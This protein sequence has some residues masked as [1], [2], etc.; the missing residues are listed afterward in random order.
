VT[1]PQQRATNEVSKRRGAVP[2]TTQESRR[3]Y[4][5]YFIDLNA[6]AIIVR[7]PGS[8]PE[9]GQVVVDGETAAACELTHGQ[10][11]T[12]DQLQALRNGSIGGYIS[13]PAAPTPTS[14]DV[15]RPLGKLDPPI[16]LQRVSGA[17][18]ATM[19]ASAVGESSGGSWVPV[20]SGIA[21]IAWVIAVWSS[22]TVKVSADRVIRDNFD[23]SAI[24]I[25]QMNG[26]VTSHALLA[27]VLAMAATI[28]LLVAVSA[29][30]CYL[31]DARR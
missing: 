20:T 12:P 26:A 11:L 7:P 1:H 30:V 31:L 19:P 5:P 16:L 27:L 2:V 9:D 13:T 29:R 21:G 4:V 15:D 18:H 10:I 14:M 3:P 24:Q 23:A 25:Q 28:P 17:D 22:L 8:N 6:M